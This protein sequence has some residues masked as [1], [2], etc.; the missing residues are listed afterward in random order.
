MEQKGR[1]LLFCSIHGLILPPDPAG[2]AVGDHFAH[3]W[4]NTG[5]RPAEIESY[6]HAVS[7]R[8]VRLG[9]F[10]TACEAECVCVVDVC[11]QE[12]IVTEACLM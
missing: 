4:L 2:G 9:C 7:P 10:Y 3:L 12:A 6:M 8:G 11:P 1:Y 5:L